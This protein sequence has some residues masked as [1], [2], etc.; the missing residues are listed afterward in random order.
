MTRLDPSALAH[1]NYSTGCKN[2]RRILSVVRQSLTTAEAGNL[3]E[4]WAPNLV[5][6][7]V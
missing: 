5:G 2:W 3:V 4:N 6:V 1:A 7:N